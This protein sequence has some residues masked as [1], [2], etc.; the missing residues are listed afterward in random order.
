MYYKGASAAVIVYDITKQS[1]FDALNRWVDELKQRAP[2]NIILAIAGNKIDLAD[3][4]TVSK[5]TVENYLKE[6]SEAGCK[7]P[8]YR[9]CSAKSG[10]GVR[11]L[12]E[13][14]C[15]RLIKMAEN[16]S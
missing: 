13:E 15:K 1:S 7:D 6:L 10:E 14:V 5:E 4:R 3:Q 2:P 11:D 12:F 9:E 16:E 8:I